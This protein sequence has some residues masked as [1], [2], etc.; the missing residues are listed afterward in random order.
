MC[1]QGKDCRWSN[2]DLLMPMSVGGVCLPRA[3]AETLHTLGRATLVELV[4]LC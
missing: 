4:T 3:L 2:V 1:A